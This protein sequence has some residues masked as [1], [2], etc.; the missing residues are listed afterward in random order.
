P[1]RRRPTRG[2]DSGAG[3]HRG[4]QPMTRAARPLAALL[5]AVVAGCRSPAPPP[6][7]PA[8]APVA[9]CLGHVDVQ[10]GLVRLAPRLQ[11][12]VKAVAVEEGDWVR[13]GGVLVRLEDGEARQAVAVARA[14]LHAAEARL[15][16]ARQEE[17]LRKPRL[18]QL[19]SSLQA[20]EH[21]LAGA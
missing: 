6:E 3:L 15:A 9:V 17:G 18:A 5:L 12:R 1:S 7:A 8:D 13:A 10:G 21:R 20:V 14:G 4:G 11:G 16:Q 2:G 19:R